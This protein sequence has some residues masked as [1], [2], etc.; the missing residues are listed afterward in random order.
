MR[1]EIRICS[2][3]PSATEMLFALGLGDQ[4]VGV[5]HECDFPE[6]ALSKR[7][8]TTTLLDPERLSSLEI[9]QTVTNSLER[10]LPI[11]AI[12]SALLREV[13][14]DLIVTQDLCLVCAVEGS[15]VRRVASRLEPG[16]RVVSLQP[17]SVSDVLASI[18][19]L[20]EAAG[21]PER[22]AALIADLETRTERL[23]SATAPLDRPGVLCLEWLDPP[24]IAGHWMP[25][26]VELAGGRDALGQRRAPSWRT[27]WAELGESRPDVV[28]V[29]PCGFE[30]ERTFSEIRILDSVPEFVGL[31]A[32]EADRVYIVNGS[33][34][35]NRAGPR[36][37][38]GAEILAA[39]VHPEAFPQPVARVAAR[40]LELRHRVRGGG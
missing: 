26:V 4:V 28:I 37:I 6:D 19:L 16:P 21:V 3:L 34:Y 30:V 35:F 15:Q 9:D 25:E 39:L 14:P 20:A 22:A 7:K 8:I 17:N 11:Y 12:D 31:P 29:M 13:R 18:R 2:L 27:T 5:S 40:K 1:T 33:A 10:G 23:R 24:W 32:Y 36:L 38:E